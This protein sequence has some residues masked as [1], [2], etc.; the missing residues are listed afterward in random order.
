[1]ETQHGKIVDATNFALDL[2]SIV[3]DARHAQKGMEFAGETTHSVTP[4][5]H[6]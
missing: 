4:A 5:N 6:I 1:M 3:T 2:N